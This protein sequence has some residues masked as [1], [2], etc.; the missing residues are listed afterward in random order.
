MYELWPMWTSPT[1][2]TM[3]TLLNI[4]FQ[5][6]FD[7]VVQKRLFHESSDNIFKILVKTKSLKFKFTKAASAQTVNLLKA[8]SI[9]FYFLRISLIFK[10]AVAENIHE[11]P[12]LSSSILLIPFGTFSF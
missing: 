11:Y 10:E 5:R 8:S 9:K 4:H 2:V 12:L 1:K 3:T 6:V 7:M